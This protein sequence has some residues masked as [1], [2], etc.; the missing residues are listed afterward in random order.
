MRKIIQGLV[1]I[2]VGVGVLTGWSSYA[3]KYSD[4]V[5]AARSQWPTVQGTVLAS[6]VYGDPPDVPYFVT[7]KFDYKVGGVTYSAAQTWRVRES[8]SNNIFDQAPRAYEAMHWYSPGKIVA[9][10]YDPA[11]PAKAKVEPKAYDRWLFWTN[12]LV[13]SAGGLAV[14]MG[15][16]NLVSCFASGWHKGTSSKPPEVRTPHDSQGSHQNRRQ[17]ASKYSR[18]RPGHNRV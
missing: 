5:A 15:I 7:V 9:V 6:K 8:L 12:K 2:L 17:S 16:W 10:Y 1:I 4:E 11:N 14:L 13:Y 3:E 18:R